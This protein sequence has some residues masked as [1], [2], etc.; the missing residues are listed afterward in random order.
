MIRRVRIYRKSAAAARAFWMSKSTGEEILDEIRKLSCKQG[1]LSTKQ[2]ELATKQGELATKQGE[3]SAK[4]EELAAK[5]RELSEKQM[6]QW[7]DIVR[8]NTLAL[9]FGIVASTLAV[10][11]RFVKIVPL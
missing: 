10:L 2:G 5:Q 9:G 8:L 11:S 6:D 3:L 1:E 7:K 4:Q